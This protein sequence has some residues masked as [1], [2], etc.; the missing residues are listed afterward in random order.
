MRL[1]MMLAAA[2]LV[3]LPATLAA[4]GPPRL[5]GEVSF[6]QDENAGIGVRLEQPLTP[7]RYSDL[8]LMVNFDY[9]YP[10]TR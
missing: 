6:A 3:L 4:Q 2:T 7:A 5:G 10:T 9:F 1:N 8:R